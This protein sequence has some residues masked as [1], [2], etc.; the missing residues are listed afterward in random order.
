MGRSA[1]QAQV[2][3]QPRGAPLGQRLNQVLQHGVQPPRHLDA[4]TSEIPGAATTLSKGKIQIELV[5]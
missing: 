2:L 1:Q 5:T 3:A 4:L